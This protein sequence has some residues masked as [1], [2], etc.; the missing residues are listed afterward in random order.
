MNTSARRSLSAWIKYRQS[1][2]PIADIAKTRRIYWVS[3]FIVSFIGSV[4][5]ALFPKGV[6]FAIG[7]ATGTALASI[8]LIEQR[9]R[10]FQKIWPVLKEVVDWERLEQRLKESD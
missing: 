1:A 7:I 4:S 10:T 2:D 5:S 6:M 9:L 3:V 8:V